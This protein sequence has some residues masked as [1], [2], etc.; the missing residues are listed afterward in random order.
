MTNISQYKIDRDTPVGTP[1]L[2]VK[3]HHY[4]GYVGSFESFGGITDINGDLFKRNCT[5][6]EEVGLQPGDTTCSWVYMRDLVNIFSLNT[7]EILDRQVVR[8]KVH[9]TLGNC[10]FLNRQNFSLIVNNLSLSFNA[11]KDNVIKYDKVLQEIKNN[12]KNSD[13]II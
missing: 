10:V 8:R 7:Q 13:S 3:D 5:Y 2:I 11:L 9:I 12:R 6:Y 4:G 1:V